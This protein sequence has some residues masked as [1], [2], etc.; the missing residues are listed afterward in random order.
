MQSSG[1]AKSQTAYRILVASSPSLLAEGK[2]DFWDSGKITSSR[3]S[4]VGYEGKPLDS[5][6]TLYWKAMVWDEAGEASPWSETGR[7]TMGLLEPSDWTARWIGNREDAYP[8]ST[9]T[10]PAPYFRKTFRINKPVKQAKAYIC[11][12]GFYE[13]YLN[14]ERVGDQV[15]APAV[16]NFDRRP[17][18]KM[19][20]FFDD[21][22]NQ[23]VLYNTF[24]VTS[25]VQKAEN[26]VGVLLGNGWY[27]QRDRTVEG[28]MWYDTPRLLCQLEIE[29]TDGSTELVVTDDSWKTT[30][31]PLLHD[32]IF[33]GEEYDA[34]LEL[35][36][37]NRNGYKDSSWKKALLVR[38]PKGSLHAQLA[39]HEK[40][41]RILQ[42]V[43][44]EQKDDSTYWYA[45]PEMI[46][47]W[48]HIKVQGNA[49]DRIKLRFVG[50]EKNDFGQV[51]LY[52]LR[53]GGVEQWEPRFTWHTF[54][55]I[56]V[57][58]RQV[59]MN[60]ESLVAKVVHTDPQPAGSFSCSNELFNKIN[61]VYLR[62][63][64]NNFHGSISSDC[65]H[66]ERLAYT[67][68]AQV[69]VESSILSFDMT[70]FCRKWFD[71]MGDARNRK[72]G[73][74]PHTA[75]FG[76]GVGGPAWG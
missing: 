13:M 43:S 75:D 22:S 15:L 56:E 20:Y 26:T 23:R 44:C 19:L 62:T 7:W 1:Q 54:R 51:D 71:D 31:G 30:T 58:S 52:T 40:I 2:A 55:Y 72:S 3:S 34:R 8:D 24:D 60:K 47:G 41:I 9:L 29:Y 37:W 14:G 5:R 49:G 38:A 39:P 6:Q 61:E 16:T 12:L 21:Q 68:D 59:R 11:G 50:E 25:L 69:V 33:T 67:G 17:L 10:T 28:C 74:V 42:P 45:F 64:K 32:A 65:P 73:F 76:G 53:G 36:G 48:A 4:Q 70:Q 57:I 66:R 35:D 27:N 46:S 18:K 63:Q